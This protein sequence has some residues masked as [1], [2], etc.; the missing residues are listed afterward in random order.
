MVSFNLSQTLAHNLTQT[1]SSAH[2]STPYRPFLVISIV[3]NSVTTRLKKKKKSTALLLR[4][5]IRGD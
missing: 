5:V 4:S 2:T 1:S 3:I